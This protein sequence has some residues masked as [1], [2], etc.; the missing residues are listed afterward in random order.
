MS[1]KDL[2]RAMLNLSAKLFGVTFTKKADA[3]I[4]FHKKLN[5]KHPTT[6]SDKLCYLELYTENPLK[7][8]CSDKYEVR[9]YVAGKGLKDILIPLCQGVC[10]DVNDI[11]FER[12][13]EQ[14]V[15]KATHGS[16]MNFI[17]EDKSKVSKEEIYRLAQ[18]WL[19][20]D[21]PRACV[22]PHYKKIPH[23]VQFEEMLQAEGG[24]TDYKFHCF[25]GVPDYILVCTRT[26]GL[27]C[28]V[29]NLDWEFIDIVTG[30]ER[31]T[32]RIEKPKKLDQMIEISK[33]LSSDFDFV[34]VDL[35]EV[36]EKVYFGELTYTPESGVIHGYVDSFDSEKGK[37]LHI[38]VQ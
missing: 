10:S 11:Q 19:N 15:M 8:K 9:D 3:R 6:L 20:E 34:R 22:E 29:Y 38:D 21:Y 2:Y 31:G 5:L 25:H 1:V 27:K 30:S 37:L 17:C 16:G 35:Y 23:R 7:V 33:T 36:N 32:E 28:Y 14:F 4:R 24:I 26:S 12:L 18:K 13:P